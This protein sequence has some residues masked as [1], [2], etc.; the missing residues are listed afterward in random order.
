M[1]LAVIRYILSWI[2]RFEAAFLLL[3]GL[4]GLIYGE[5]SAISYPATALLCLA[6]SFIIAI[7]KP[8][9]TE[10]YAREGFLTVA[11]SWIVM[12]AFGAL[13]F[14][15]SGEIPHY[16][17][18]LFEISSGL[19]TTGASILGDVGVLSHAGLFWRSFSHWIG[20]MGVFLF[21]MAITPLMGG[22]TMNL[23]RAESSG[24]AVGKLV[25][26][27]K[28]TAKIL[29]AIYIGF[30]ILEMVALLLCGLNLF[31]SMTLTFG[32]VGTGG[33]GIRNDSVAGFSTAVQNVIT[34]FMILSGIN[35][36]AYFCLLRR[37]W[38]D[39]VSIEEVRWYIGIILVSALTIT[40]SIAPM[41]SSI[42][43]SMKHAFFQVGSIITTTGYST[44]N[45]ETWPMI[46]K[47][48]LFTLMFVGACTGSTGGG[49]KIARL[50]TLLKTIR[51]E[52][53]ILAHPRLV[54]RIKIDDKTLP[55]QVLRSINVY[56]ALYCMIFFGSLL[57]ISFDNKDFTTSFTAVAATLNNIGPGF[58][59]VGPMG[60]F[61]DF[62]AFSK[63]ILTFNMIA[64]RLELFPILLLFTPASWKK[65]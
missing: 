62:S 47:N 8:V 13:P 41:Y 14:V 44:V 43:E 65:Y 34:V 4:V 27:V 6:V 11:L 5:D 15:F 38:K 36:A 59:L 51:K 63:I 56:L 9:V 50:L 18:A 22:P 24:P 42:G 45:Y 48:I 3:P 33:F 1:N 16:I 61:S 55:H 32:T 26:R 12:S 58:S 7:R 49:I 37:K 60:N 20:G 57:L 39:A 35:F 21:I 54:R 64:G 2:L 40:I 28:D 31:D 29:Y 52:I 17:D 30:T 46:A 10:L 25:P 19:T 53:S 23:M